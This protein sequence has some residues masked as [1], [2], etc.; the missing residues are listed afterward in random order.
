MRRFLCLTF[1]RWPLQRFLNS[2][3]GAKFNAASEAIALYERSAHGPRIAVCSVAAGKRGVKR[4]ML[5]ADATALVPDL[6]VHEVDR[7]AD[8]EALKKLA[9]FATRFSPLTG[10][11]TPLD[12]KEGSRALLLD[13]TGCSQVFGGEENM[14]RQARQALAKK[15]FRSR[16]AI[17]PTIGACWALAHYGANG[18]ILEDIL[19]AAGA[20]IDP[21][22]PH[23]APAL[24]GLPL[25]ALRLEPDALTWLSKLG[26]YRIGDV[27]KQPR[28]T[29]PSRFGA[30]IIERVDQLLGSAPEILPLLR[31][32]P[33][34]HAARAFEYAIKNL[35][36]LYVVIEN[37]VEKLCAELRQRCRG[38][39]ELECWLYHEVAEPIA[40]D[41]TLLKGSA[42][43]KHLFQ[44][45]RT[46]LE[47]LQIRGGF[48]RKKERSSKRSRHSGITIHREGGE[49]EAHEGVIAV[50][51][52]INASEPLDAEQLA[53]FHHALRAP[54][55]L[56]MTLDRLSMRL[57]PQ[58]VA[59][60]ELLEDPQPEDAYRLIPASAIPS[61]S[62]AALQGAGLRPLQLL[63]DPQP[64]QV[65]W[66]PEDRFERIQW[67]SHDEKIREAQGPE[68]IDTGWWKE[69]PARRDYY[70]VET[71]RGARYWI[72][73][74][75]NDDRWFLQGLF[76]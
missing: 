68:R 67:G 5:L 74:R 46:Q 34:F 1:P 38:A 66:S 43:P 39:R 41:V 37:L 61:S 20:D 33:E 15:N 10:L 56:A 27:L 21:A 53:L 36:P 35:E 64:L 58:A 57:G 24:T 31:P 7:A 14:L 45:L 65:Y 29:L 72:F 42:A 50:A 55:D 8:T 48:M 52:R 44:L 76:G 11:E 18:T 75:L 73:R 69:T 12:E 59:R 3:E 17:A 26:L 13:I 9:L 28:A 6:C 4:G 32:P 19:P 62:P 16:A 60:V 40:V 22:Q 54:D 63:E 47:N 71:E 30:H 23:V 49:I 2:A 51:L 70:I 25:P